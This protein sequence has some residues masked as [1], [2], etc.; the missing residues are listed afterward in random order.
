[1][2][3]AGTLLVS[4]SRPVAT[5]QELCEGWNLVAYPAREAREVGVALESISPHYTAVYAY[6][7]GVASP[8]QRHFVSAPSWVNE[9]AHLTPGYGYWV[10][11]LERCTLSTVS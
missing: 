2:N 10:H 9:L 3:Q 5:D 6:E 4:G 11:V 1:M 7:A 8:W